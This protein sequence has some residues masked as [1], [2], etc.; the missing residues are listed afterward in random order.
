MWENKNRKRRRRRRPRKRKR[1]AG[2]GNL[3]SVHSI[4]SRSQGYRSKMY[5]SQFDGSAAF[6]GGGFMPSQATQTPDPAF[7]PAKVTTLSL[8]VCF[9]RI[10]W[11]KWILKFLLCCIP[12]AHDA[13]GLFLSPFCG[14][15]WFTGYE[16]LRILVSLFFFFSFNCFSRKRGLE[17]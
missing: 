17:V 13:I 1:L 12:P 2:T 11:R 4:W 9:S 6:S 10:F 7:S 5:G 14:G 16:V 3:Q 15:F 8:S